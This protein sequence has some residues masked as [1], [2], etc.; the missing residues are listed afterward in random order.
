[1]RDLPIRDD[2]V[3]VEPFRSQVKTGTGK[4]FRLRG[5]SGSRPLAWISA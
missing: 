5:R 4:Y 3:A 2:A 1:M